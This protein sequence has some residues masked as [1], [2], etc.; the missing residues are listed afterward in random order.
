M[1]KL[2]E[3]LFR[4]GITM[5]VKPVHYMHTYCVEFE[6]GDHHFRFVITTDFIDEERLEYMFMSYLN[7]FI[8]KYG[9]EPIQIS[10][11]WK[12]VWEPYES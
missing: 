11:E 12:G 3:K 9:F 5:I 10:K 6:R 1:R 7:Q 2:Y 8:R 4:Y